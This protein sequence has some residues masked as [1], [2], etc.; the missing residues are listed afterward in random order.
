LQGAI[1]HDIAAGGSAIAELVDANQ[2]N[3]AASQCCALLLT[4]SLSESIDAVKGFIKPQMLE[5]LVAPNRPVAEFQ[6]AFEAFRNEAW[7]LHRKDNQAFY[8]SNIENL[9]KRIDN[10]AINAPQPKVDAEMKRRLE[11]IFQPIV[12]IAYQEVHA[13]PKIDEIKLNGPRVCLLLSP[14]SKT[15]PHEA[16]EFWKSVTEKNNFCVVTGDGSNIANL[17]GIARRLWAIPRVLEETGGEK[18]P[19][20]SE[21]EEELEDA[22]HD[23]NSTVVS[24]F[25]RV[26][27]PTKNQLTPAKLSM[28]FAANQF[29]AEEQIEKALADVGA[30]KLYRSVE[31][32]AEHLMTRAEDML[33]PQGGDRRV[34]W[35]DVVSRSL[36]NERWPWLEPKGLEKL[37]RIA[38]GQGRWRTADD[39]Y[40]EKGPFPKPRTRVMLSQR[41]YKEETGTATLEV[42]AK[43]AGPHGR[44]HY[45]DKPQVTPDS[46]LVDTILETPETALW[47]LAVDPDG[48]HETGD[49]LPWK[50]KLTLTHERNVRGGKHVVTIT[51]KPRGTIRWNTTAANPKEGTVYTRPIEL[52]G[53]REITIYAYAE[54][55]GAETQ[56]NF[57]IPR[58]DQPGPSI[59]KHRPAKLR[60]KLEFRGATD[61]F[62]A[63]NLA[64]EKQ[65]RLGGGIS[66][67]V[68]AGAAAITTRFGSDT[69]IAAEFAHNLI[70]I[71]R[72]ALSSPTADVVLR[73]EE[74]EFTSGHDLE[75]FAEELGIDIRP[76][77]IEQ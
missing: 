51:V 31:D 25:N 37:R 34:P 22:E 49:V 5:Y 77:E 10:R 70:G 56:R 59:E 76:G 73:A 63:L 20:K 67:T 1:A 30:S 11:E 64:K 23:F 53:D 66:L 12:K 69:V 57:V 48:Q 44:V 27:Y 41:D 17:E 38:E 58:V 15:P 74:L 8:F 55:K 7:Y 36:T 71:Y 47:F 60:K 16:Q 46:P 61:V 29:K 43:D 14:D 18:S 40:I 33:W 50:N 42:I 6:D 19:H 9:K 26:Y 72:D 35:R 54:D 62:R 75:K 39:G 52:A 3:D 4:A 21:L 45:S 65:V 28:T 2:H 13:L 32:N 68:G 24:L